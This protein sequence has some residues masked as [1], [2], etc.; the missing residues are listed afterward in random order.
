MID[1][2][3][4]AG[5]LHKILSEAKRQ[6]DKKLVREVWA[7]VLSVD[8]DDIVVTK[9]VVALYSLSQEIQ[10]LIK[11][12]EGLNHELYLSSFKTIDKA[13]FPLNLGISWNNVKH[14]LTEEAI[15]RLQ[16]CG[17]ELSRFYCE[18]SLPDEDLKDIIDKTEEL[19]D[20]IYN[21]SL[22]EAL[23][24][25]LLEEIERIRNAIN[26]YKIKGAKGLKEAL[27]G[28]IGAVVANQEELKSVSNSNTDVIKRLGEL[29][30]KMDSF[31]SRALKL[32]K[33]LSSPIKFVLEKIT[34]PDDDAE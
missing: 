29:I 21:G 4:P 6:G 11:M 5:R 13:F 26:M 24:L 32:K 20:S 10:S 23:R 19:F 12:K 28:T 2:S 31:A 16:F 34:A 18:E 25:A 15:T 7:D 14:N 1:Q 33:A 9:S 17:E 22:S 3:N 27:Q 8:N 30:D